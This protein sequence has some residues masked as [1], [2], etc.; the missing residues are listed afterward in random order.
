M[1]SMPFLLKSHK[2]PAAAAAAAATTAIPF[3]FEKEGN[4]FTAFRLQIPAEHDLS[5]LLRRSA[6]FNCLSYRGKSAPARF[7]AEITSYY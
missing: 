7:F 4:A 3:L 6:A 5:Y 1:K 2:V